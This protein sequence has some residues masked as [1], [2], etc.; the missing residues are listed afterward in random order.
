MT[1]KDYNIATKLVRGAQLRSPHNETSEAL[2]MTS[3]FVYESAEQAAAAFRDED[4]CFVYSRY[5][6]PTVKMFEQRL[7]LLE[8]AEAC[9]AT[10]TGMAAV[11]G[12]LACQLS[13]GDRIVAS[14]ALFG[15][16]HAILTKIL[17]KWGVVT[18]LIDGRDLSAWAAA[19]KTPAKLVFLESPSNPVLELVD[20]K[21]VAELAH[22]A[23]AMVMVDNVFASP[24]YQKPL[25][26]GAD[27]VIYSTTK[28]IDGQGRLLGGAVLGKTA[29]VEDVFLPFYRQTGAAMSAFNAWV[30]LKSL[31]TLP[32]RVDAQ[33]R[34][35]AAVADFL[36]RHPLVQSINYPGHE[37]HPQ[38]ALA[39][40][41][42]SGFGSMLAF[43]ITGGQ[44]AAFTFLNALTLID[45]SNNLGDSK[46]LACHPF[47]TTHA[48]LSDEDRAS[49]NIT[50]GH[51]RISV[52]LED[53]ADLIADIDSALAAV[54]AMPH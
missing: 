52:G 8:G 5:G 6:N 13:S 9:R 17:P 23:G 28:H 35:A 24:I 36:F 54:A 33:T 41:Q 51:I 50:A 7:A 49:L 21:A 14:R 1:E 30:M 45:I 11:F 42:M 20:I 4:D 22:A 2:Y 18:E 38:H 46:S 19:L 25:E 31:E 29:F 48:N 43:Q 10:G 47:T 16:C 27:I 40:T 3:G 37:S 44:A 26:L 12:A 34:N 15:A 39:K 32:L 53:S